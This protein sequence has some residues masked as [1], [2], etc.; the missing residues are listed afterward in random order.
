M[1]NKFDPVE[2]A[3][4]IVVVVPVPAEPV[5]GEPVR[6]GAKRA[7]ASG[8]GAGML[9]DPFVVGVDDEVALL[10]LDV[11]VKGRRV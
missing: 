4:V 8:L 5:P 11:S 10:L 9:V 1:A 6:R 3:E 7:V 2:E